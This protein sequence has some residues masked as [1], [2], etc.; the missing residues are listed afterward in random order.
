MTKPNSTTNNPSRRAFL[1]QAGATTAATAVATSGLQ[2]R[3]AE[4]AT[5]SV[6]GKADQL[7]VLQA[8]PAVLET[9]TELLTKDEFTPVD[10]LFVRNNQQ[11]DDAGTM[12]S[13]DLAGWTIDV[14]GLVN[15][16]AKIDAADLAGMKQTEYEM[17]LQCSG[18]SRA[19][20]SESAQ[21][22][23]TQWGR[24]GMGNVRFSG[25]KLSTALRAQGVRVKTAAKL[26]TAMGHDDPLPEKEDF[27]H[28]PITRVG[29]LRVS[30]WMDRCVGPRISLID[31][32]KTRCFG[33]TGRPLY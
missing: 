30:N 3:A 23:G 14:S 15:N 29:R 5:D 22:K 18:N 4:S 17:V 8:F 20:F 6:R 33:T 9:P 7:K 12:E 27:E 32:V 21:T 11:P 2:L 25:V 31:S 24:G 13:R 1:R 28:S 16:S 26:V 10:L 19:L